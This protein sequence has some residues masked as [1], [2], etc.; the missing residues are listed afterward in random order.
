MKKDDIDEFINFISKS[1]GSDK[2]FN[3]WG[4]K[5]DLDVENGVDI[6]Q[7][8][9]RIYLN[10]RAKAK[11]LIIAEAPGYRGCKWSGIPM[12]SERQIITK[13]GFFDIADLKRSSC[14]TKLRGDEGKEV[15]KKTNLKIYNS[16]IN[17]GFAEAT[18]TIVWKTIKELNRPQNE[19]VLWN[20]FPFHPHPQGNN[21]QNE[22]PQEGKEAIVLE[23]FIELY[24]D[25]KIIAVGGFSKKALLKLNKDEGE[26]GETVHPSYGKAR[27]FKEGLNKW[28][29][30]KTL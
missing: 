2:Y 14:A 30:T 7:D 3:P 13:D 1:K 28:L 23:Q 25:K 8:N 6:R 11:Y 26:F 21:Y 19:F 20:A 24:P 9:L 15:S 17:D 29:Q 16:T 27:E 18:A 12:T 4:D 22:G 10:S 5:D